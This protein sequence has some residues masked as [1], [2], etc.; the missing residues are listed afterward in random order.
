VALEAPSPAWHAGRR[1][2]IDQRANRPLPRE[3]VGEGVTRGRATLLK[4]LREETD[5]EKAYARKDPGEKSSVA[6]RPCCTILFPFPKGKGLGVRS[7]IAYQ[8][9]RCTLLLL[10]AVDV[11]VLALATFRPVGTE[12]LQYE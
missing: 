9:A 1:P 5:G 6:M 4:N 12:R 3:N 11:G 10:A 2:K 7:D 8:Q